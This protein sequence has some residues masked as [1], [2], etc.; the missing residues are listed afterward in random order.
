MTKI[1][2]IEDETS[3]AETI[4]NRLETEGYSYEIAPDGIRGAA[5]LKENH[6][7]VA[8]LD[9]ML[10]GKNGFD[11]LSE[12]RREGGIRPVIIVTAKS[13]LSDKVSGLRLGADDYITKPFEFEELL[14]RI[15]VQVKRRSAATEYQTGKAGDDTENILEAPDYTF[16][17]FRLVFKQAV[18]L[19]NGNEIPLSY[20]EFKLLCYFVQHRGQIIKKETLLDKLWGYDVTVGMRT[21][22][23]HIAWLRKKLQTEE[24][25]E[26][27]IKT[28]RQIGYLFADTE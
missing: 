8:L 28:I 2:I 27:Y 5:L 10:P 14:A 16:G 21:V 3:L 17:P 24:N 26:G 20:Q 11:L 12:Y 1:L 25:K 22:Y 18:L 9:I 4:A 23:T 6:F 13:S 19:K 15:E 7:D